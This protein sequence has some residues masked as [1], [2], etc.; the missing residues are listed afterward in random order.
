M[1][2]KFAIWVSAFLALALVNADIW[3][4]ERILSSGQSVILMLAPIDPR[5]LIQGD[6][7]RLRYALENDVRDRLG[8]GATRHGCLRLTLDARRVA[9][10]NAVDEDCVQAMATGEVRMEYRLRAGN[11]DLAGN[12]WFFEEG[13]ADRYSRTRYGEFRVGEDGT[14]LLSGL[15]DKDLRPLP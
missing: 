7:M 12:S 10:L 8:R 1:N 15:R 5:S 6:Y 14:A 11:L 4:K 13:Q 9:S 2:T 3:R